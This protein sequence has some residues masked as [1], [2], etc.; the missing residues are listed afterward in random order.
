MGADW[1]WDWLRG[2]A[3]GGL[4]A[5]LA[6]DQDRGADMGWGRARG[7]TAG[8]WLTGPDPFGIEGVIRGRVGQ[9]KELRGAWLVPY[10][11]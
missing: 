10:P 9:G 5:S 8:G 1:G 6:H 4:P 11:N 3:A 2:G 7:G